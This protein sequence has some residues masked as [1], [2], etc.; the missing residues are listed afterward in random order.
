LQPLEWKRSRMVFVNSMGDLFH[1]EV[2]KRHI[3]EVFRYDV[4]GRLPVAVS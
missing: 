2:S 3:S 4:E 1:N